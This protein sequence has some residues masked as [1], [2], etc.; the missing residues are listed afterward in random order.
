MLPFP[1][2]CFI[3]KVVT[4]HYAD[5]KCKE[6]AKKNWFFLYTE[7][8]QGELVKSLT[9]LFPISWREVIK[10]KIPLLF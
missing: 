2:L 6:G 4:F 9:K 3:A 10:A 8:L 1:T 7:L 5:S